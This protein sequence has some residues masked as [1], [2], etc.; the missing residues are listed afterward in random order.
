MAPPG[1]VL[2]YTETWARPGGLVEEGR[3]GSQL[4]VFANWMAKKRWGT[5][6]GQTKETGL[7][8]GPARLVV[9]E[10]A[11]GLGRLLLSWESLDGEDSRGSSV[12]QGGMR[13]TIIGTSVYISLMTSLWVRDLQRSRTNKEVCVCVCVCVCVYKAR[14]I[15]RNWLT[16]LWLWRLTSSKICQ[17]DGEPKKANGIV[18]VW[19]PGSRL[20]KSQYFSSDPKAEGK[21]ISQFKGSQTGGVLPYSLEGQ[22][23]HAT[24][25]FSWLDEASPH[26]E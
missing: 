14:F 5:F 20:K 1:V 22:R 12:N 9:W 11:V 26:W 18:L 23:L 17:S 16:R 15:I 24:Q 7:S 21:I 8:E 4:K 13:E 19:K 6:R 25:T 2:I 3:Q 10:R